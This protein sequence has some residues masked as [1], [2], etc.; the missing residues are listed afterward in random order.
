MYQKRSIWT[1]HWYVVA[2]VQMESASTQVW[3]PVPTRFFRAGFI[4]FTWN[5]HFPVGGGAFL[6]KTLLRAF[7]GQWLLPHLAMPLCAVIRTSSGLLI[8]NLPLPS[9]RLRQKLSRVI[10]TTWRCLRGVL[11]ILLRYKYFYWT[12]LILT[13]TLLQ[14]V[15][16]NKISSTT[17]EIE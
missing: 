2:S 6:G 16:I 12:S 5:R 15:A 11:D 8:W 7:K 14:I 17:G 3:G 1:A 9:R 4:D 10:E 13:D